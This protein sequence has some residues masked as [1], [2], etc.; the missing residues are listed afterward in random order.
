M[1]SIIFSLFQHFR[2]LKFTDAISDTFSAARGILRALMSRSKDDRILGAARTVHCEKCD[3]YD[4]TW[5][6]CGT[7]GETMG[8]PYGVRI[9]VGCWCYLPLANRDPQKDCYAK[10]HQLHS[11]DGEKVG[12]PDELR[13]K[14][15]KT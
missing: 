2:T 12:W 3:F 6:T 14:Q 8:R 4:E 15:K 1:K 13:P 5:K 9:K 11:A 7:P 10:T